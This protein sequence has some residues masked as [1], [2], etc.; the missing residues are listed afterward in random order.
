MRR[1]RGSSCWPSPPHSRASCARRRAFVAELERVD[2]GAGPLHQGAARLGGA[3]GPRRALRG[4]GRGDLPR[5]P[6][7]ASTRPGWP[8]RSCSRGAR[9]TRCASI[10]PPGARP[11]CSCTGSTTSPRSSSTRSRRWPRQLRRRRGGVAAVRGRASRRSRPSR[12]CTSE[13]LARGADERSSCRRSTTTTRPSR[14]P[15]CTTWSASLFEDEPPE[16]VGRRRRRSPSTPPAGERAEIELAGARVLDLLRDGVGAGRRRGGAARPGRLRVAASSRS[17]A[18]TTSRSRSTARCRWPTPGSAAACSHWCAARS[19]RRR[20]RR[21][22]RLAAHARAAEP[23]RARRPARGEVRRAGAIGPRRRARS[24]R[25]STGSSTSSTGCARP[26]AALYLGRARARSWSACS[27][28]PTAARPPCCA[29]PE[30]DD[31]RVF[32]AAARRAR[33]AARRGGARTRAPRLD[34]GAGAGGAR[35]ICACTSAS[36]PQPDRVQVA[37]PE[38][39][40]ARRF[41]AVL[42]QHYG[43]ACQSSGCDRSVPGINSARQLA[44]RPDSS[45]S[46]LSV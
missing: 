41:E 14:A 39:I 37:R 43:C 30:L 9:S 22:A 1:R 25:A 45:L 19:A 32:V 2:G 6:V 34:A 3:T 17:S 20:R 28:L 44:G 11:P 16:P 29:G 38:A 40:R 8:T 4:R 13:L 26:A 42:V 23:A 15:R 5:L 18:P 46:P 12:P 33:A 7:R 31:P 35:A 36:R 24:G 10:P 21:P 27:R